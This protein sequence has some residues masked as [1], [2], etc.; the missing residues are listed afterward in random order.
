MSKKSDNV[1]TPQELFNS[2]NSYFNFTLDACASPENAKCENYFTEEQ[3]AM[4]QDWSGVVFCNPPYSA[5]KKGVSYGL[6][7]W[8]LRG[9]LEVQLGHA[10]TVVMLLPADTSTKYHFMANYYAHVC[11]M[12]PRVRFAGSLAS[13][14]F[15]SMLMILHQDNPRPVEYR[16]KYPKIWSWKENSFK[17]ELS[18]LELEQTLVEKLIMENAFGP[19]HAHPTAVFQKEKE[20]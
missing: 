9:I 3:D 4:K 11:Y 2:L 7:E 17:D 6:L 1:G 13:A 20:G 15:G 16:P 19:G 18:Y 10:S 12:T 5:K 8:V 14:K